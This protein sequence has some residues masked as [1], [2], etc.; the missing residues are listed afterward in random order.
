ML[1]L[2]VLALGFGLLC[3][4]LRWVMHDFNHRKG[5]DK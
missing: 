1:D 3:A 2:I 5:G 4:L